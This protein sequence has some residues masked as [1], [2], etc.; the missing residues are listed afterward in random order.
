[1]QPV[2][3]QAF[4]IGLVITF[5]C[6][7]GVVGNCALKAAEQ[8]FIVDDLAVFLVV[9]IEPIH[10]ANGLEQA[11]VL[12]LFVDVEVGG[13]RRIEAGQQLIDHDQ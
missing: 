4:D 11:M 12:H 5:E 2:L 9:A 8:V 3:Q 10:P 1:M 13:R 7:R 6:A